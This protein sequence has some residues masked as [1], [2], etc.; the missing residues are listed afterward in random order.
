MEPEAQVAGLERGPDGDDG[1]V[2]QGDGDVGQD[3]GPSLDGGCGKEMRK[4]VLRIYCW[5]EIVPHIYV[6]LFLAT[7]RMVKGA[8][9][10]WVDGGG[11]VVVQMP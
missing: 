11:Q 5:G 8:G 10:T 1:G 2:V 3:G 4:A 6:V 9:A 7:S